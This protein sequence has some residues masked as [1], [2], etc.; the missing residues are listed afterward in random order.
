MQITIIMFVCVCSVTQSCLT[1]Q[2]YWLWPSRLLCPWVLQARILEWVAMPS[3][4]ECP[5]PRDWNCLSWIEGGF[6]T[7][8]PHGKPNNNNV[9][10]TSIAGY[11]LCG[12]CNL[13]TGLYNLGN[14]F[15]VFHTFPW[16][17]WPRKYMLSTFRSIETN[18]L[19][20]FEITF[21][22]VSL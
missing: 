11:L 16:L 18:N 9:Y 20:F 8:E 21:L 5:P 14:C 13:G 7:T 19:L 15:T 17:Y 2:P 12:R 3:S 10:H 4:R 6:F 22:L 1:L